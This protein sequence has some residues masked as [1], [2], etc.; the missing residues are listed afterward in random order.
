[1]LTSRGRGNLFSTKGKAQRGG[2]GG[3]VA[4]LPHYW[5]RFKADEKLETGKEGGRTEKQGK[6]NWKKQ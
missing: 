4:A 3:L 6:D 2:A 1:M 5:G